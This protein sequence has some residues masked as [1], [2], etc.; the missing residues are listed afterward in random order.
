MSTAPSAL[1][2]VRRTLS[3]RHRWLLGAVLLVCLL[4]AYA[5]LRT[6]SKAAQ[7]LTVQRTDLTQTVA[8]TGRVNASARIDL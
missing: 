3:A 2:P 7:V 1:S 4:L 6:P 5:T 8:A